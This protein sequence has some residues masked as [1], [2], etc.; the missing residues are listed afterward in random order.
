MKKI[1]IIIIVGLLL[2]S[3]ASTSSKCD[4]YSKVDTKSQN[5]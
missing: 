5:S 2:A 1:F 3:C 4:A